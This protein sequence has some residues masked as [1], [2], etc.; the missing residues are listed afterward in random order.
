MSLSASER[1]RVRP[2]GLI[3]VFLP[4]LCLARG[5]LEPFAGQPSNLGPLPLI[6]NEAIA[7]ATSGCMGLTYDS[8]E[9]KAGVG[10]VTLVE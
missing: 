8:I 3:S 4:W 6:S 10:N 5:G 9:M 1:G 7:Y 2:L